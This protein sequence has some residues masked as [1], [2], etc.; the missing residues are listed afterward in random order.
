[1]TSSNQI[2]CLSI[3]TFCGNPFPTIGRILKWIHIIGRWIPTI[4]ST[5]TYHLE[6]RWLCRAFPSMLKGNPYRWLIFLLVTSFTDLSRKFITHHVG[7]V[8]IKHN[9]NTFLALRQ[10]NDSLCDI[11]NKFTRIMNDVTY[12]YIDVAITA[13]V[14]GLHLNLQLA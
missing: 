1:M 6:N 7:M 11:T 14:R 5:Y 10:G 9:A 2:R 12:L 4:T 8:W 3:L 13:Y